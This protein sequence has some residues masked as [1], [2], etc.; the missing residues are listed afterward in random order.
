MVQRDRG[1]PS[2]GEG[3]EYLAN[4]I[5]LRVITRNMNKLCSTRIPFPDEKK[6]LGKGSLTPFPAYTP[7]NTQ[8]S[9]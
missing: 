8:T 2:R 1:H 3:L 7:F 5:R 9:R 4:L 6:F